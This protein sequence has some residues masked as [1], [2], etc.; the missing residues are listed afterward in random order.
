MKKLSFCFFLVINFIFILLELSKANGLSFQTAFERN[1]TPFY[2]TAKAKEGDGV[3]ALL[4]RYDLDDYDCNVDQFYTINSMEEDDPLLEN[5]TYKIPIKVYDYNGKSIRS[6]I[7][8]EDLSQAKRIEEYNEKM[9]KKHLKKSGLDKGS[10]LWVPY[11]ELGC[12]ERKIE[13]KEPS[14]SK[15]SSAIF[16]DDAIKVRSKKLN[17]RVFYIDAGHGGPDPGAMGKWQGHRICEDEYAYDVSIRLAKMLLENGAIVY[18][19]TRDPNDGIRNEEYLPCDSDE[20]H[21]PN[22]S[23]ALGQ[24]K[25][26]TQRAAVVNDLYKKNKKAG[27]KSQKLICIHVDSRGK[28]ERTDV[29]FYFKPG[30]DA[31]E[32][33][34]IT[35]QNTF[36]NNY[37]KG[38]GYEGSVTERDLFMLRETRPTSAYVELGN[39]RNPMDMQRLCKE[40][41]REALASWLYEGLIK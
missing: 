36:A 21:Y 17:N 20:V 40:N 41:N 38:R 11:H 26:L 34:A 14:A 22:A 30:S 8:I 24:K 39:L 23:M 15:K 32:T 33:L 31:S 6:T 4:R 19:I 35:L 1:G 18:M 5:K 37:P 27:V 7:D 16:D 13:E 28:S 9:L 25:R 10:A 12:E 2:L 29:F 3:L